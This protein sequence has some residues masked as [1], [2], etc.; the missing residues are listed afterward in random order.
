MKSSKMLSL[1]LLYFQNLGKFI[2]LFHVCYKEESGTAQERLE[3]STHSNNPKYIVVM[4]AWLRLP[5]RN[6]MVIFIEYFHEKA[7]AGSTIHM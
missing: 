6:E 5:S 4:W 3:A 2:Y 7:S 1:Y